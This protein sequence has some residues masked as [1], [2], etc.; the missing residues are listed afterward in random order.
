[1]YRVNRFPEN[2]M[3]HSQMNEQLGTNLNG[4]SLIR[5]PD[6]VSKPLGKYYLYFAHHEGKFIRMAYADRIRGPWTVYAPGTLKLEET[7]CA[8]HIASPDLHVCP[9][10]R[11]IVMYF[12]GNTSEGQRTFRAVSTNGLEFLAAREPLGP[13]YF[14]VFQH[15]EASFAIAKAIGHSGGGVLLRSRDGIEKFQ[16]GPELLP[17]QRHVAVLKKGNALQI[18]YSRIGDCPERILLSTMP[19]EGDWKQ[20]KASESVEVLRSEMEYEGASVPIRPSS[21][22]SAHEPVHELRDPALFEEDGRLYLFYAGAGESSIC[23]AELML[24]RCQS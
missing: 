12:H 24:E 4:P 18:F 10:K 5:V 19:L 15:D 9:V 8:S 17:K 22:G 13:F 7:G 2:P 3:I 6:W 14:R 21:R 11:E 16:E 20:W 1:M 23:G